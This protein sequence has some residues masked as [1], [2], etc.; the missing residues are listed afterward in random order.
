M[1]ARLI[2]T[3]AAL[4]LFAAP[5][6]VSADSNTGV[7]SGILTLPNGAAACGVHVRV[8]SRY[9]SPW[10]TRSDANGRYSFLAVLPGEVTIEFAGIR[11]RQHADDDDYDGSTQRYVHVSANLP[12]YADATVP[13]PPPFPRRVVVFSGP[14]ERWQQFMLEEGWS[15]V[16]RCGSADPRYALWSKYQ[17]F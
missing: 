11:T 1:K 8:L 4:S 13:E 15:E 2:C 9:E 16:A 7:V 14:P 10:I 3:L 5:A 6:S 17:T 12:T